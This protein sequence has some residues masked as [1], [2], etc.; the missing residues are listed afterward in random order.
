MKDLQSWED[1]GEIELY[2]FDES[3]FSQ[4]SNLPYG[5]SPV[6]SRRK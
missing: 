2:Y 6:G 1:A 5:W 3:G 4:R